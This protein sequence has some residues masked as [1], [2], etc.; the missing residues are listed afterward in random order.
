MVF[1]SF[2]LVGSDWRYSKMGVRGEVRR[3]ALVG[4]A[5]Y[6]KKG[7]SFEAFAWTG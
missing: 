6:I 1:C 4:R 7:Y 5:Q 3:D 2:I